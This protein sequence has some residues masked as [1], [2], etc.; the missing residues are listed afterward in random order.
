[1]HTFRLSDQSEMLDG[2][3]GTAPV[4]LLPDRNLRAHG[5]KIRKAEPRQELD[6]RTMSL[7]LSTQPV[8]PEL[9]HRDHY[10]ATIC[11]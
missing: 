7:E 3:S 1:M 8:E 4:K 2:N 6:Q 5:Q 10:F 11:A 9:C